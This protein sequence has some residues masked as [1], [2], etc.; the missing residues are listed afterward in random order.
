MR[1]LCFHSSL[2]SLAYTLKLIGSAAQ[3]QL[4]PPTVLLN[5]K[6]IAKNISL[7]IHPHIYKSLRDTPKH[8][9][10][11]PIDPFRPPVPSQQAS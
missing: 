11:I 9:T 4:Q 8:P 5:H 1:N 7:I 2:L 10:Y 6:L 3:L